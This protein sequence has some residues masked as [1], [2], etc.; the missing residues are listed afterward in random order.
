MGLDGL[1]PVD[2]WALLAI[3]AKALGYAAALVAMG[4][5]LFL[6]AHAVGDGRS[7]RLRHDVG[8]PARSAQRRWPSR[9]RPRAARRNVRSSPRRS[10]GSFAGSPLRLR[11]SVSSF[12]RCALASA[13]R[14]SPEWVWRR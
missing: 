1:A 6:L 5:P 8:L 10:R 4:G 9:R 7:G 3:A 2:G 14:A 12:W 13:P 11:W